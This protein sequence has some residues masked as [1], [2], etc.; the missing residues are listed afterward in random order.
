MFSSALLVPV[1]NGENFIPLFHQSIQSLEHKFDEIIF[2]DD[3]SADNSRNMLTQLGYRVIHSDRN[4]GQAVARN[5]LLRSCAAEWVHF[6]DID[7]LIYPAFLA[8]TAD[9][10]IE[11][12][13]AIICDAEWVMGPDNEI[14]MK[15]EYKN[16]LLAENGPSYLLK[17]PV[18][19][20]NG[21]YKKATLLDIGGFDETLRI[22]E[23]SDLNLRLAINN[24][25]I[26]F[27][28]TVLVR[29]VRHQQSSSS[30]PHSI[31]KYKCAFLNKYLSIGDELFTRQVSL[32]A[33]QLF[34]E[35]VYQKD[36]D[37]YPEILL[38]F[39]KLKENPPKTKTY[40]AKVFKGILGPKR[41]TLLKLW[42]L[43]YFYNLKINNT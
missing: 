33:N 18:G 34:H 30:N 13:D 23:D 9:L 17:N 19:G 43:R 7:D 22:W 15:W 40:Y 25:K 39:K 31:R 24:K 2:Y 42:Y 38:I 41:F 28:E 26:I 35:I 3:G 12:C 20:I 29:A 10:I 16:H 11:D 21:L 37:L 4:A 6:H 14:L 36:W 1:F 5:I 32:Q 8:S 27:T